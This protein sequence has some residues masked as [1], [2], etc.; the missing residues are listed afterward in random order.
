MLKRAVNFY[1]LDI[2]VAID[3]IERYCSSYKSGGELLHDELHWDGTIRELEIVGEATKNLF[4]YEILTDKNHRRII[5][6]RNQISHGYFGID[7]EIVW[8]VVSNKLHGYKQELLTIVKEQKINLFSSF[9]TYT[10]EYE[11]QSKVIDFLKRFR[12]QCK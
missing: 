5:D 3:K 2:F 12:Q 10:S 4:K 7:E 9:D 11:K 8:D 6:F 1:I